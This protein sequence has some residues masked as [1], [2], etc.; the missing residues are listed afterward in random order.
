[1]E[2]MKEYIDRYE[3]IQPAHFAFYGQAIRFNLESAI[4]SVQFVVEC[5]EARNTAEDPH[6]LTDPIL[7]SIQNILIHTASL[8]KY[9]WPIS[10]GI[11]K[12]HKKR[13][14]SLRK[15]FKIK[16]DSPIRNKD[17]RNH[18]EHLDENLDSYLWS[19]PIVGNVYPA[20][21][22]PEMRRDEVPYHFFR[23][24]FTD[25]GIFESLGLRLD[26]QPI[27]D[28]LYEIYRGESGGENT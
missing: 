11:N 19:K 7:D 26:I 23:A 9:F 17:L 18:L 5:L 4:A 21:V 12:V 13:A 16:S 6:S 10:K 1:M 2:E 24:F 20:Y 28:E 3:G 27:I 25:S 22:G 14:Q 8:S 15:A